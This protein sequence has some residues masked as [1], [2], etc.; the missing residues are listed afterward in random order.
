MSD[1]AILNLE[2]V[3][4]P[5]NLTQADLVNQLFSKTFSFCIKRHMVVDR[6]L[7]KDDFLQLGNCYTKYLEANQIIIKKFI[8]YAN[9]GD[10]EN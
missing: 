3:T 7:N 1:Q 5:I 8:T 2:G 4:D 10:E 9:D 6:K